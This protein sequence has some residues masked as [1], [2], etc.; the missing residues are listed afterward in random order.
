MNVYKQAWALFLIVHTALPLLRILCMSI[1]LWAY[2]Q[3]A[4]RQVMLQACP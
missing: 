1:A 3:A 4:G 2:G